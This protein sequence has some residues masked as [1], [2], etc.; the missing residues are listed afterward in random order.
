MGFFLLANCLKWVNQAINNRI[1]C[2]YESPCVLIKQA[3]WIVCCCSQCIRDI[4]RD[5]IVC[6]ALAQVQRLIFHG[7]LH[8]FIPELKKIR[9]NKIYCLFSKNFVT[10]THHTLVVLP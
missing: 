5:W 9:I 6:E 3:I 4:F 2:T 7:Q 10:S 1:S 8:V